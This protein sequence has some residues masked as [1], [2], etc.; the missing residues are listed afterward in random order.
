MY[1]DRSFM[2]CSIRHWPYCVVVMC[3]LDEEASY[4]LLLLTFE[5][6]LHSFCLYCTTE[7]RR[8]TETFGCLRKVIGVNIEVIYTDECIPRE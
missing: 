1:Q 2:V 4:C 6:W 3:P 7:E 5:Y 8:V